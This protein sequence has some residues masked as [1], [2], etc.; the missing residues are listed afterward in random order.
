MKGDKE[1]EYYKKHYIKNRTKKL[2]QAKLYRQALRDAAIRAYGGY[3]CVCLHGD[4][5]CGES[6]PEYLSI[7]HV[8]GGGNQHRKQVGGGN[9]FYSWL[10]RNN[11]PSGYRVLCYNCNLSSGFYGKCPKN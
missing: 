11:Y 1:R 8:A 2:A 5:L 4:D 9:V 10:K 6:M 3:I 7:D